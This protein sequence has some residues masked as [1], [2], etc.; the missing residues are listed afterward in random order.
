MGVVRLSVEGIYDYFCKPHEFAGMVGRIVVAGQGKVKA[1]IL[2]PY[3]D[4]ES[5]S[6]IRSPRRHCCD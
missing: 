3:P 5:R 6:G 1:G 4:V 2:K